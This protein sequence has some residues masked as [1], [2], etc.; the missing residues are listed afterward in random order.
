MNASA[1]KPSTVRCF[2]VSFAVI[3]NV[4][5]ILRPQLVPRWHKFN[6]LAPEWKALKPSIS[7]CTSIMDSAHVQAVNTAK[8]NANSWHAIETA[9]MLCS[10]QGMFVS[11][12]PDKNYI[13]LGS[14]A[15]DCLMFVVHLELRALCGLLPAVGAADDQFHMQYVLFGTPSETRPLIATTVA[16]RYSIKEKIT[17]QFRASNDSLREYFANIF[18]I[19]IDICDR[20]GAAV[21]RAKFSVTIPP[22]P[23]GWDHRDDSICRIVDRCALTTSDLDGTESPCIDYEF[24]IRYLQ[25]PQPSSVRLLPLASEPIS[26]GGSDATS[27][28]SDPVDSTPAVDF[29]SPRDLTAAV[30]F[31]APSDS[32]PLSQDDIVEPVDTYRSPD[33]RPEQD[34]PKSSAS[35]ALVASPTAARI[36][37]HTFSY[38]L[39]LQKVRFTRKTDDEIWQVC[40]N[41]PKAHTPISLVNVSVRASEDSSTTTI[42]NVSVELLFSCDPAGIRGVIASEPCVL[43]IK[44]PH[45]MIATAELDN[46]TLLAQP[47]GNVGVV[48][49]EN[50]ACEWVAL[51]SAY[52]ELTDLGANLNAREPKFRRVA[53]PTIAH[54][55]SGDC[56]LKPHLDEE[57]AFKMVE[58]LEQWKTAQQK[59]FLMELKQ[60]ETLHLAHLTA[61]WTLRRGELE[62]LLTQKLEQC[63]VLTRALETANMNLQVSWSTCCYVTRFLTHM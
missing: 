25:Q 55:G 23:D 37:A 47:Q 58:E 39:H 27:F 6:G 32:T 35:P 20:T 19:P 45:A 16:G 7:L 9:N 18:Y 12:L 1:G 61:E 36:T 5:S 62:L 28:A 15:N 24:V 8:R 48:L 21:G 42:D 3:Y 52:V 31:V 10:Q 53:Q 2:P 17:I 34:V 11:M 30:D 51:A 22:Q 4:S 38:L 56:G 40:L 14:N 54:G 60:R 46:A 26:E 43:S 13:Q 57:L 50:E 59:D 33:H 49:M 44:G 41:H 63:A 29:V